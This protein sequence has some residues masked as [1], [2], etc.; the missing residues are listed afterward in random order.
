M[1]LPII[2]AEELIRV[3][4]MRQNQVVGIEGVNLR[5]ALDELI[6]LK[7]LNGPAGRAKASCFRSWQAWAGPARDRK[8]GKPASGSFPLTNES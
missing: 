3:F 8:G 5:V 1:T 2:I 4:N 7:G 6:V